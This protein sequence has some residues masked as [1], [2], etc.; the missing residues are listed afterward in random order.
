MKI[1]QELT[2]DTSRENAYKVVHAKQYDEDSRFLKVT[3]TTRGEEIDVP[4]GATVVFGVKRA[5]LESH[6]FAG[7]VN[8]D[9]TVTVPLT[10]WMLQVAGKCVCDVSIIKDGEKFS[11]LNFSVLVEYAPTNET[12][13]TED[14]GYDV[15]VSLVERV[16]NVVDHIDELDQR[17]AEAETSATA[18]AE[19][20]EAASEALLNAQDQIEAAQ[21]LAD[22]A[23]GSASD[24]QKYANQ[25]KG[26]RD[27]FADTIDQVADAKGEY[28]SLDERITAMQTEIEGGVPKDIEVRET[29]DGK[30]LMVLVD[31]EGDPIGEGT[32]L[33]DSGAMG[34]ESATVTVGDAEM[35]EVWLKDKNGEKIEGSETRFA[36]GSGGG[37]GGGGSTTI[38]VERIT[39]SPLIITPTDAADIEFN[40]SSVDTDG[41]TVD[42]Y[43]TWKN[44][45]KV[46]AS[47]TLNQGYNSFDARQLLG[48]ELPIGTTKF[49]LTVNDD[50][51][52]M[53]TRIWNVQ[54]VDIRLEP[55]DANL[56]KKTYTVGE[57]ILFNYVPYGSVDKRV[58]FKMDGAE[59]GY[60]DTTAS[61]SSKRFTIP[62]QAH[63][64]HLFEC[65]I[66]ASISGK[67]VETE[68]I[69]YDLVWFDEDAGTPVIGCSYRN[70]LYGAITLKQFNTMII[71]FYVVD[72]NTSTPTITKEID[73]EVVGE[74]TLES[75]EGEWSVK[76][77][78]V[79][80]HHLI[81]R[82]GATYV[83]IVI[84]TTDIGFDV[85]TVDGYVFDFN[86]VG[87]TNSSANRLWS[88]ENNPA[89]SMSVS[90]NF[91]WQNGGYQISRDEAG[92]AIPG[93][94]YFCI[95]SGTYATIN[96]KMFAKDAKESGSAFKVIFKTTN[97]RKDNA[98]FLTCSNGLADDKV[99]L[100]MNV[101][102]AYINT[103]ADELYVPYSEEDAIEFEYNI[104]P[105]GDGEDVTSYIMTY[106]DGVGLRPLLYDNN[107]V[108]KQYEPVEIVIGSPDCDVYIYRMRAYEFNLTD[109][110]ILQN[111]ITDAR[112]S[113]EMISRHDRNEIY[114]E[115][116]NLTP[117]ILAERC[118]DLRI[119]KVEAPWFTNDKDNKV[120]GTTVQMIYKNGDPVL[121][122]WTCTGARHSGQGTSSNEYG[123]AGRN[124]DLIMDRDTSLF[125]FS[126]GT[127]GKTITLTRD[128]VPTDYLNVKVNIASSENANNALMANRYNAFN[129]FKR[130]AKVADSKV[131]D[132]MEF[133]NCVVFIREADEDLSTHRE[134]ND[135]NWHFYAFGNVGDS[136]KTDD[137]RVNDKNDPKECVIEITDYNVALA[138]FPTGYGNAICTPANW[139][140]GNTAYDDLYAPYKYKEGEFKSFGNG[141]YEFRYEKKG[142]TEEER[143]A[144]IDAWRDFYKFVVTSTD[145]EFHDNLEN[146]FVVDS[147]LY[148]YLFTERYT[149]VDNRAKNSFWHYGK[150]DD[151]VYRWDLTF[152]YDFD[153]SLG[154]DNT[155]K[156]VLPYGKEDVDFYVDGDPSSSYIYRAA[157]SKFFCRIR[158][159]FKTELMA[160]YVNREDVNAWSS[161]GL[162]TQWDNS[163]NQFPEELW[164]ID[165]ERKYLRTYKGVSIDNSIA[166]ASNP[167]FF[168]EMMNGR[169]KYQRRQFERN[170]EIYFAT[171]Y[172]GKTATADQIMLR[173]NNP[174][175]AVVPKDFTLYL[176]PYSDMYIGFSFYNGHKD[177]VRA[178]AGVEYTIPYPEGLEAADITLIYGASFIQGIGDL[179]K[180]Y[181][182]DNDFS[183]ASRL[184]RL[185]IGSTTA[186]YTNTFMT[187]LAL[188]NNKLLEYLDIR[189]MTGLNSIVDLTKC[190]NLL[191]LYA[192]GSSISGVA[193]A[194]NGK[195]TTA[196][197][198]DTINTLRMQNLQNLTDF[199]MS[200]D[201]LQHLTI[202]HCL[203]PEGMD[204]EKAMVEASVDTLRTL[205]LAGIDWTGDNALATTEL[206]NDIFDLNESSLSGQVYISGQ[207][208][209]QE[210][211]N[212][213]EAWDGLVVR[214]NSA[215]LIEQYKVTY[216]DDTGAELCS[217][218]V[219][220]GQTPPDP[221]AT[222][223]LDDVPT[224]AST[225]QY[226]YAFA[227]W[228]ELT[229]PVLE[230]RVVTA[231]F[232]ATVRTY[233]VAWYDAEGGLKLDEQ[234]VEYGSDAVYAGETPANE[235]D[236]SVYSGKMFAGWD[237]STGYVRGN[238]SV[239]AVWEVANLPS[240]GTK[241]L[242]EMN[243]AEL[244]A[245]ATAAANG[246]ANVDE[247]FV[248]KDYHDIT[249]GT[250]LNFSNIES[251]EI[252]PVDTPLV[253]DGETAVDTDVY[254]FGDNEKSFT[255]AI[256]FTFAC[257]S[258][259][260][261]ATLVS[262][263]EE[264]G[265]EGFR[266]RF[267]S[268]PSIQWGDKTQI[269]GNY[270]NSNHY[271]DIV[272]IRHRAGENNLYVYSGC[273][274]S[275]GNGARFADTI[276]RTLLARTRA[277][278][279]NMPI[280]LGAVRF[281]DGGYD[282]YAK[283]I[284]HWCKVWY[285][286]L[287]ETN[288]YEL[289]SW[290]REPLRME[291]CGTDRYRLAGGT[292]AK[293]KISFIANNLL[294]GRGY[295]MNSTNTNAGGW[296]ASLMRTFCNTRLLNALPIQWRNILKTVKVNASAGSQSTE[297]VISEDKIYLAANTEIGGYTTEPYGSEGTPISWFTSGKSRLKFR[298]RMVKDDAQFFTAADD[299][300]LDP[301]ATVNEG[302][303]WINTSNDSIGYMYLTQAEL[304]K[305]NLTPNFTASIGGGWI[306][307]SYWWERSPY[308]SNS[309]FFMYVYFYGH[310][311]YTN[312]AYNVG[313]VCPCFS[314]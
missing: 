140:A 272:V 263:F 248:D 156:L 149:M 239:Y 17:I 192:E 129:P 96:Y 303:I 240:A 218:Y 246:L 171:K 137:T 18:A 8:A 168:R 224:K 98:R 183:K 150:C 247:Y 166:G 47:G 83:E 241:D 189:N 229:S 243:V 10:N 66:T 177:N 72:P 214:Y 176:T 146:Y 201:S 123:Y 69:Y 45:S 293:A 242:S 91:D 290:C 271:R 284:I 198:P 161:N 269:V 250:D 50:A 299:P 251:K 121:D 37:G 147:A 261:N 184:Q 122:N 280:T 141:S 208:R 200:T 70:D 88:D 52:S 93:E 113:D 112:T 164:R 210:L 58:H 307:A 143:Q 260:A 56:A 1:T 36:A 297:I 252:V 136:K 13:I 92:N 216:V 60:E 131:K 25:A 127:T 152:G 221:V 213:E 245:V 306:I 29:E 104:C 117:E 33:P 205:T 273:Q 22:K 300:T 111:F 237:K 296:D 34:L 227:S 81:I 157:E 11:T 186:G 226:S 27:E 285:D 191:E 181:V 78:E 202:E 225:P 67:D 194:K 274:T 282:F 175:G 151:G 62:A 30:E 2:L 46:L 292:S 223:L 124:L 309:T 206:L 76:L 220:R 99:G 41:Q 188:G 182:G 212:Y 276:T 162:I 87:R 288:A 53:L 126:D 228:N 109:S 21:A 24:A 108:I 100:V 55:S 106:E 230:A 148:Y 169:K 180:C 222:G 155:G 75:S 199:Q 71:P 51:G 135:T 234:T 139:K 119:I 249:M 40:F 23:E 254:L 207:V 193:F 73:G 165:I 211:A 61:G 26:Y 167:R 54:V 95:K 170:Q 89:I 48:Q 115:N 257:A 114:D 236:T 6:D 283:G 281:A 287:G 16:E 130:S 174:V 145:E 79:G 12:D 159:L 133:H 275:N 74:E 15:L 279:T 105:I 173:F 94:E 265:S 270:Y 235:F 80:E 138:E 301:E 209:S 244:Y 59:I 5:D 267:N 128:S 178:K 286:D 163:Q 197:L 172:F 19:S 132:C 102:E 266:L 313:G 255:M 85:E 86:P 14:E 187:T 43:Y 64:A 277:T 35:V 158:D 49:S 215:N 233:T 291:F 4:S 217:C 190:Y 314:I 308:A 116:G 268:Y 219:D 3:I 20:A 154:I 32:E 38:T 101:H 28:D 77:T 311:H 278:G 144:N 179:S 231:V 185:T 84:N 97:V 103:S 68:H 204:D 289:A 195:V 9:G 134:F 305:Y 120:D 310:A 107:H 258:S 42:G 82:C 57:S 7:V 253:L 90:D 44:G 256:D 302:D 39:P 298:G 232:T 118:P 196:H 65:Y 142:I 262:A 238:M 259:D 110:D 203:F 294:T 264:E 160:M 63:G 31:A 295:W 312:S 153:T 304:D 125:T